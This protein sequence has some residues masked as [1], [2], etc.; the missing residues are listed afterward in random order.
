MT[1]IAYL[2]AGVAMFMI[3]FG[4]TLIA[5]EVSSD[6]NIIL[7]ITFTG[8]ALSVIFALPLVNLFERFYKEEVKNG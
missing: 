7:I 3:M 8:V 5:N 2:L 6:R 4:F 1:T